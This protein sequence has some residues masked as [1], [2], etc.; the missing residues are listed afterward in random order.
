MKLK[1]ST[2]ELVIKINNRLE[3]RTV[4]YRY[5]NN[6]KYQREKISTGNSWDRFRW[7]Y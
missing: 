2:N 6:A 7:Y 4:E 5:E 3:F 1:F